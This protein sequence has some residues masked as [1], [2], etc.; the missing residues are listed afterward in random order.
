M[1]IRKRYPPEVK[2]KVVLEI[3]KETKSISEISSEYGIHPNQLVRWRNQ[4]IEGLPRLFSDEGKAMESL[5]SQHE[6][7]VQELYGEIGRLTTELAWLKKKML[8]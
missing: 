8:R 4:A 2:A 6:K 3:L 1:G 7:E 5:K